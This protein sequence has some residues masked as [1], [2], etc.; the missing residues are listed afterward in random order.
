MRPDGAQEGGE[1]R[2]GKV[3]GR[4]GMGAVRGSEQEAEQQCGGDAVFALP[5]A[6]F[7]G[8]SGG[9]VGTLACWL[10]SE[11]AKHRNAGAGRMGGEAGKRTA[12]ADTGQAHVDTLLSLPPGV[13]AGGWRL[14]HRQRPWAV[15]MLWL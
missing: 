8:F 15:P 10:D 13:L 11:S 2:G 6:G 5:S 9:L 4:D 1:G 12:Q 7:T 14:G 3:V